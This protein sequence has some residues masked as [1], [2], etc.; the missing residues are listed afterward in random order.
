M[1]RQP[2]KIFRLSHRPFCPQSRQWAG[3]H[4]C[5]PNSSAFTYL[6]T[7][8][9]Y[10]NTLVNGSVPHT[11]GI[12]HARK[13]LQV[14]FHSGS[15]QESG[16]APGPSTGVPF[17]SYCHA[18]MFSHWPTHLTTVDEAP[19]RVGGRRRRKSKGTPPP[20]WVFGNG[21]HTHTFSFTLIV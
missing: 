13:F 8:P 17:I 12:S 20:S 10:N 3:S 16:T 2:R 1:I 18:R 19:K 15:L 5:Q 6:V 9:R 21:T 11:L 4:C 7:R 14:C